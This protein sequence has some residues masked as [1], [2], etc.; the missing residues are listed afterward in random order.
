MKMMGGFDEESEKA[1]EKS[2]ITA[3]EAVENMPTVS[4]LGTQSYFLRQYADELREPL[5]L[6]R[7]KA[8][9]SSFAFAASEMMT[10]AI[11]AI[12]L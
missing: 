7:R 6:G 11:W 4:A 2:A 1:Y 3:V 10:F 5:D 12:A 9:M 8:L